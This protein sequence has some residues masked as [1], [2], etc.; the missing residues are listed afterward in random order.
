VV[1][2]GS[3]LI[4]NERTDLSKDA[5]DDVIVV[6]IKRMEVTMTRIVNSHDQK[7]REPGDRPVRRLSRQKIIRQGGGGTVLAGGFNAHSQLWDPRC[8]E[9]G[10]VAHWADIIDE[11]GLVIG[12]DYWRTHHSMRNKS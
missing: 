10:N 2:K 7:R 12:N 11:H 8:T 9:Q 3:G 6:D 4:N 1:R 5:G